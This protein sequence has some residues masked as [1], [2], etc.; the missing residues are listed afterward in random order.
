MAAG[1][2][3]T[4]VQRRLCV[5]VSLSLPEDRDGFELHPGNVA[6]GVFSGRKKIKI[7]YIFQLVLVQN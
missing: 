3:G 6:I 4:D 2:A 1:D 7:R 5:T